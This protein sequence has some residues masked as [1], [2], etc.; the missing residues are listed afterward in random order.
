VNASAREPS[1]LRRVSVVVP[2]RGRPAW[3]EEAVRSALDQDGVEVEVVVALD[4]EEGE[5]RARLEAIG[6][7][8]VRVIGVD[9]GGGGERRG[10]SAARNRA[11]SACGPG[12]VSFLDDDDRLLPGALL[13]R[14]EAL[15]R[16]PEAALVY[17]RAAA[18]DAEGREVEGSVREAGRGRESCRSRLVD[19][20]KGRSILPSTVLLRRPALLRVGRFG[21]SETDFRAFDEDLPTGED[22]VFFLRLA[23]VGPFVF[24]P[25]AT[26]LYRRHA[27]Q[28]RRD[29]AQQ[30]A[31]LPR[32]IARYFDDPSTPPE[33]ARWRDR[34]LGTHLN[35]ISRNHRLAGDDASFRRC[36]RAAV[37]ANPRLLL[38]PRRLARWLSLPFRR[39]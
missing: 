5:T 28:V 22:W 3:C 38:H 17:G 18:M 37:A 15:E 27:G 25:R 13:A 12:L 21:S 24:L 32:W 6:D 35:W 9:A 20:W 16:H 33:A 39:A 29:P 4:G 31:A 8:R 11:L 30:E 36:F 2:T 14:V 34:L 1:L 23:A 7:S 19:H 10:R 26:V